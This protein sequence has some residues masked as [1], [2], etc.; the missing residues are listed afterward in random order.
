MTVA[1]R[2]RKKGWQ[3]VETIFGAV[4]LLMNNC[5]YC[6][7]VVLAGRRG[8]GPCG[9]FSSRCCCR[10]RHRF[11]RGL[12][13]FV[14]GL[15]LDIVAAAAVI[16]LVAVAVVTVLLLLLLLLRQLLQ[17]VLLLVGMMVVLVDFVVLVVHHFAAHSDVG[18]N[19]V[20]VASP[21]CVWADR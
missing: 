1:G 15:D 2:P 13:A 12:S 17:L 5:T 21:G 16:V 6:C 20:S 19:M 9:L 4:K 7:V 3:G 18:T 8:Y 14:L 11:H 10:G